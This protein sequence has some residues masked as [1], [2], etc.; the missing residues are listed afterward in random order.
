MLRNEARQ[1]VALLPFLR[2]DVHRWLT[3][4]GL[5]HER[6]VRTE[7]QAE[8]DRLVMR[9]ASKASRAL[10]NLLSSRLCY[11]VRLNAV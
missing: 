8:V 11:L 4:G 10:G 1:S 9:I 6:A 7:R 3:C 2:M 5:H